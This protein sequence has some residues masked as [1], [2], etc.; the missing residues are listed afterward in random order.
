MNQTSWYFVLPWELRHAGGVNEVV[1]RLYAQFD[2]SDDISPIIVQLSDTLSP[3]QIGPD[4]RKNCRL[5][6]RAPWG[7]E[8]PF[9]HA[10][11]YI[12][13]LICT[14]KSISSILGGKDGVVNV[15]Y[16]TIQAFTIVLCRTLRLIRA[17]VILSVHGTDV[18]SAIESRG[19]NR[20]LM[21]WIFSNADTITAPSNALARD[22]VRFAPA[23]VSRVRVVP[24][25]IDLEC[26]DEVLQSLGD[27]RSDDELTIANVSAFETNKGVDVLVRAFSLVRAETR[28][29]RLVVAGRKGD[30]LESIKRIADD[31][32]VSTSCEFHVDME[33]RECL[34]LIAGADVFVVASRVESFG[35]VLL[36][37][38][39]LGVP[40]VTTWVDGIREVIPSSGYAQLVDADDPVGMAA[41]ISQVLREPAQCRESQRRL[42][43][44]IVERYQWAQISQR[45]RELGKVVA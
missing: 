36:E 32:G 23:A 16:P 33:H 19:L 6:L 1:R 12:V 20:C 30:Q 22:V 10:V 21:K 5:R 45:F 40:I 24:N 34:K 25:G 15:H 9:R 44:R 7:T 35:I 37:A 27:S 17:P 31:L 3:V 43:A 42:R 14:I 41:A 8:R 28:N 11:S 4:G 2:R 26:L 38:G 29:V 18:R 39:A 13:H